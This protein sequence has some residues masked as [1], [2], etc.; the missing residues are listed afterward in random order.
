M[1]NIVAKRFLAAATGRLSK[2]I[3]KGIEL[4]KYPLEYKPPYTWFD[5][6]Q[7]TFKSRADIDRCLLLARQ[8]ILHVSIDAC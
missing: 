6:S 4:P 8:Y 2:H 5:V 1:G 7:V 3:F